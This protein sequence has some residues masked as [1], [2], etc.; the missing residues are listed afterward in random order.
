MLRRF[1]D[2]SRLVVTVASI[3]LAQVLGGIEF[4]GSKA[5]NFVGLTRRLPRGVSTSRSTSA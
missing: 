4:V 2:A 1:R 3:G 5:L